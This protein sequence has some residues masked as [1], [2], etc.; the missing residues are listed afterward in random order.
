MFL[1]MPGD[2]AIFWL[3]GT[4]IGIVK[5]M[6]RL[7]KLIFLTGIFI[8]GL[9]IVLFLNPARSYQ[10]ILNDPSRWKPTVIYELD[11]GGI[12]RL[13]GFAAGNV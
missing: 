7:N 6:E 13:Q 12:L 3:V 10:A 11:K 2:L 5:S 8:A 9:S 4:V 1:I